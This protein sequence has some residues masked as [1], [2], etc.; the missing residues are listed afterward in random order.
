MAPQGDQTEF[1]FLVMTLALRA[2]SP[3]LLLFFFLLALAH[4]SHLQVKRD[5]DL[6]ERYYMNG[7]IRCLRCD[8]G[9]FV[10]KQCIVQDTESICE[11]CD[12]GHTYSEHLTGLDYCLPCTV[13]RTDEEELSAC[14]ITKNTKCQC[15]KGTFCP[16]GNSCEICQ[17]C[18]ASCPPNEVIQTPCNSTSDVQCA[19]PETASYA[20]VA[21]LVPVII[22]AVVCFLYFYCKKKC[23]GNGS[24]WLP[25]ILTVSLK[26]DESPAEDPEAPFLPQGTN[27]RFKDNIPENERNEIANKTFNIFVDLIP[28]KGFERFMR[29][30]GL[31]D[32]EIDWAKEDNTG[33]YSK[34]YAM[35]SKLH[36]NGNFDVNIWLNK[37]HSIK[38]RKVAQD[39]AAK[40]IRDGLFE[41]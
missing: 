35:L 28:A 21:I 2:I 4:T 14:S 10:Q 31:T 18:T 24:R 5:Y 34:H 1:V 27:L 8:P 22:L 38:M 29:E 12:A 11:P 30:L 16:P 39:I 40:L 33:L 20:L 26:C 23:G 32:N 19:S 6:Y 36:Q 13:C 3:R 9:R 37:L 15:K 41:S 17:K 7:N 25:K